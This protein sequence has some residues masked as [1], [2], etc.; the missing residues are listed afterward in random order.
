MLEASGWSAVDLFACLIRFGFVT[1][2]DADDDRA[3]VR[4]QEVLAWVVRIS[5]HRVEDFIHVDSETSSG[6]H[7]FL[8]R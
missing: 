5:L 2:V 4:I 6:V 7:V 8:A 3:R 1:L